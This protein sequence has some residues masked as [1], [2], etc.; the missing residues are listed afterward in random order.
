MLLP[1]T[2]WNLFRVNVTRLNKMLTLL[3]LVRTQPWKNQGPL[4]SKMNYE[5]N[6]RHSAHTH[7][8][9]SLP[10]VCVCCCVGH[11]FFEP[12][13]LPF[14]CLNAWFVEVFGPLNDSFILF[15]YRWDTDIFKA[16]K[17]KIT[18][19]WYCFISIKPALHSG[20]IV[21]HSW[22]DCCSGSTMLK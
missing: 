16:L 12:W 2:F 10:S 18:L 9:F 3:T 1:Y 21:R 6:K 20:V 15:D 8:V 22:W 4:H 19:T 13:I 11:L 7:S 14:T 5:R 17:L